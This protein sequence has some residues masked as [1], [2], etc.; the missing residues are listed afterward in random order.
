MMG[1]LLK[2]YKKA[3]QFCPALLLVFKLDSFLSI[4]VRAQ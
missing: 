3:G 4:P 1:Y 2:V